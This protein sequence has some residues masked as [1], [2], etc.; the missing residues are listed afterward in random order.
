MTGAR[1]ETGLVSRLAGLPIANS[2][3][4]KVPEAGD[5]FKA[6]TLSDRRAG[7]RIGQIQ[8]VTG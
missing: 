3:K 1:G 4:R 7:R 2:C 8:P 6:E 5:G